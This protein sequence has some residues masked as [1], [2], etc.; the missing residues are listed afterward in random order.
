MP[1][2]TFTLTTPQMLR[3]VNAT[4]THANYQDEVWDEAT[5]TM[6]PNPQT[7]SQFTKKYWIERMKE[8]VLIVEEREAEETA[9]QNHQI[10]DIT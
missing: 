9:R 2:V 1:D 8:M 5:Q 6:I 10:L 3:L 7:K 4:C